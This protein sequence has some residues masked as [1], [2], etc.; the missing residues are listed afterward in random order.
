VKADEEQ[1]VLARLRDRVFDK[2]DQVF[3]TTR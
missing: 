3:D 1:E 2:V